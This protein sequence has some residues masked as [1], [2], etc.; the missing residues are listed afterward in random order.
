[1][2]STGRGNKVKSIKLGEI[3]AE[4]LIELPDGQQIVSAITRT[5]AES[6]DLKQG[7]SVQAIIKATEVLVGKNQA[8]HHESVL[9][10]F[11][12]AAD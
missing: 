3:M 12:V 2:A 9:F 1:M 5:S 10:F 4:I 6:L 8:A 11:C 7:D